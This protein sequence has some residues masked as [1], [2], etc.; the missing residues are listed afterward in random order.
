M[1]TADFGARIKNGLIAP[2]TTYQ[3]WLDCFDYLKL[4]AS[5]D[6]EIISLIVKGVFYNKGFLES[7]FKQK[8]SEAVNDMLNN[9]ICRFVKD[10]NLA[11]SLN[12]LSNI[13]QLFIKLRNEFGNCLFFMKLGFINADYKNEL[14]ESVKAQT[15]KF[16]DDTLLFLREQAM[17]HQN[18]DLEDS[19]FLIRRI[20][21]FPEAQN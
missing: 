5:A 9:R 15:A 7:Q 1:N 14:A 2:P 21:L 10:L 12:E 13:A 16:W 19:L 17:E 11:I 20:A 18:P 3:D 6:G 4:G 8:L